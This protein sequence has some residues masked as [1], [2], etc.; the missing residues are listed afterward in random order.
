[1]ATR[2]LSTNYLRLRSA[3]HRKRGPDAMEGGSSS[4]DTSRFG[5]VDAPQDWSNHMVRQVLSGVR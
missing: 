5:G 2:D 4:A 3:M 1:M